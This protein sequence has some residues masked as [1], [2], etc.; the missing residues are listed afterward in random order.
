METKKTFGA[1]PLCGFHLNANRYSYNYKWKL[2]KICH[3]VIICENI[4]NA[5]YIILYFYYLYQIIL[6]CL[7]DQSGNVTRMCFY[8]LVLALVWL[9]RPP[10][11][12]KA[13]CPSAASETL[14]QNNLLDVSEDFRVQLYL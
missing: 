8:N 4:R 10:L 12:V 3:L 7:S 1:F 9:H 6:S 11:H 13:A 5:V 2:L 14:F